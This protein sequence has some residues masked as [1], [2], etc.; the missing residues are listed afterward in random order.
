MCWRTWSENDETTNELS[1]LTSSLRPIESV[2]NSSNQCKTYLNRRKTHSGDTEK[3]LGKSSH[4]SEIL[5]Q[6]L[7]FFFLGAAEIPD[8]SSDGSNQSQFG[9]VSIFV[10]L[11]TR[12]DCTRIASLVWRKHAVIQHNRKWRPMGVFLWGNTQLLSLAQLRFFTRPNCIA[13]S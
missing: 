13:G 2:Q 12:P 7:L 10:L 5:I 8:V 11:V 1:R 3:I 6:N 4:I 9:K